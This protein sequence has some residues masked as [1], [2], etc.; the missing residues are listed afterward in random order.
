MRTSVSYGTARQT[1]KINVDIS[2]IIETVL[3]E[4]EKLIAEAIKEQIKNSELDREEYDEETLVATFV[5]VYNTRFKY[6]Y[7]PAT[8]YDPPEEYTELNFEGLDFFAIENYVNEHLPSLLKDTIGI[9]LEENEDD[10]EF[11]EDEPDQ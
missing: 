11:E 7:T 5:G 9:T 4:V 8:L 2:D 1:F 6:E 3:G 10:I